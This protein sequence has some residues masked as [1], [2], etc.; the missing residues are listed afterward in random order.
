MLL[1]STTALLCHCIPI[2]ELETSQ[3]LSREEA[4]LLNA[5]HQRMRIMQDEAAKPTAMR[6][7]SVDSYDV[8]IL[9]IVAPDTGYYH[10][11]LEDR[12][13]DVVFIVSVRHT[14]G[15]QRNV[16]VLNTRKSGIWG[17][18]VMPSGFK[19]KPGD[20][21]TIIVVKKDEAFLVVQDNVKIA[22][23]L[24]RLDPDTVRRIEVKSVGSEVAED[25]FLD[26]W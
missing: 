9:Q 13:G 23:F 18:E 3:H 2:S 12:N 11:Q 4:N 21:T 14:Y 20:A 8:V 19:F 22:L 1:L 7:I 15:S 10:L 26:V 24:Y 25:A 17:H 16:L 5:I 6:N